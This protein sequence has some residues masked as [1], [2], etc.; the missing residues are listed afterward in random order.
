[1]SITKEISSKLLKEKMHFNQLEN[2]L[3]VYIMPKEGYNKQYAIF[4]TNYGSIDSKFKIMG[5]EKVIE[6]PDGIAH[7]L[8]HKL[9]EEPEGSIFDKFSEL[10]SNVNAY[11]NFT[12]TCYLFTS[13]DRFL[14][15]LELLVKFVQSPYFTDENVEKEKGIITQEIN[16]YNDNPQWKVFFNALRAM[17][18]NHPVKID[19]AGTVD[20][21][22]RITKEDLYTCYEHFYSPHNMTLFI[23][24][25][26]DQVETLKVIND[27]MNKKPSDVKIIQREYPE[28]PDGIVQDTIE[29]HLD[30]SIP[31]FNIAYKD[32]LN[33][34][35]KEKLLNRDVSSKILL[36]MLFGKSSE[37][38]NSL[39]EEGLINDTFEHEFTG[40]LGYGYSML[41]G[42]SKN[43]MIVRDRLHEYIELLKKDGLNKDDFERIKK[44]QIGEHLSYYNS[45]EFIAT[46]F[47][48][49][50]FK[51]IQLFDY[52]EAIK[53]I[54][55]ADIEKRFSDHFD[56]HKS[57]I[58]IISPK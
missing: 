2:G 11:T 12:S 3:K 18:H 7:F 54:E 57:I 14:E 51:G 43:P 35:S 41:G 40:E 23:V 38:Y 20:S 25:D 31:L 9:F 22:R 15:N 53:K 27:S 4:A 55:F 28:E 37:L 21:I 8:E 39:Y 1:M 34:S 6:V 47:I 26:I 29:E 33:N 45:V 16:M 44:K 5:N 42:E 52:I 13:T 30:V 48:A 19:I 58:S 50:H 46:T 24:G 49:Y 36:D 56:N 10:G 32:K 17:Y